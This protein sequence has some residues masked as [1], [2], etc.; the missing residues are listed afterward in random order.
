[1]LFI[2]TCLENLVFMPIPAF[3]GCV[4]VEMNTREF[5]SVTVVTLNQL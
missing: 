2:L 1:M 4:S 5:K 3:A